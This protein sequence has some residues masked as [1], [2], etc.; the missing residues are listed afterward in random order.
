MPARDAIVH[1]VDHFGNEMF[2]R[3]LYAKHKSCYNGVALTKQSSKRHMLLRG[4]RTWRSLGHG[5]R[6]RRSMSGCGLWNAHDPLSASI[7]H[8]L[9]SY[10]LV[11]V[12]R[13]QLTPVTHACLGKERLMGTSLGRRLGAIF[14]VVVVLS[15]G[16]VP[17]A[18]AAPDLAPANAPSASCAPIYYRICRGDTLSS[19][20]ARYGVT[21]WQLQQWNGI[22]NPN[23]I[24]AGRTLVIYR[25]SYPAPRPAP[26]PCYPGCWQCA[27][28]APKPPPPPPPCGCG[29][30]PCQPWQPYYPPPHW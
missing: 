17:A 3:G 9:L 21:V 15:L 18:A 27:C 8:M 6:A 11:V 4:R 1:E 30:C 13:F 12:A 28:P 10:N 26:N 23:L 16:L 25:C 24:Y 7:V 19:I 14:L 2:S 5:S 22:P 29:V 20:A